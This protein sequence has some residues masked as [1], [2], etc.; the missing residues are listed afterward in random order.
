[1]S[2]TPEGPSPSVP[3]KKSN[4]SLRRSTQSTSDQDGDKSPVPFNHFP[5]PEIIRDIK[6]LINS[7][8]L[9]QKRMAQD[10]NIRYVH[11]GYFTLLINAILHRI[12]IKYQL[13]ANLYVRSQTKVSQF[14]NNVPRTKGWG[15]FEDKVTIWLK[16]QRI[17]LGRVKED[18]EEN[19]DQYDIELNPLSFSGDSTPVSEA[20]NDNMVIHSP[21]P[22]F[23]VPL[24]SAMQPANGF[25]LWIPNPYQVTPQ[26]PDL[27][28]QR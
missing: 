8:D 18:A 17:K 28:N 27:I 26:V 12:M 11:C 14:L 13:Y 23:V 2:T 22:I 9:S 20:S 10:L 5:K 25:Q 21:S 1:M 19:P 24:S 15:S 16:E 6:E 3:R 7:S 4:A